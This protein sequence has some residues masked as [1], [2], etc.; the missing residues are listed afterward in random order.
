MKKILSLVLSLVLLMSLAVC[1]VAE[2]D[3][4]ITVMC[5]YASEDPHGQYVYKYAE[6]FSDLL[7]IGN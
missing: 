2:E 4:T 5:A 6:D 1:A 7:P 3:V